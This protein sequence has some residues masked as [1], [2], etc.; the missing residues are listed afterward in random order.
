MKINY[1]ALQKWSDNILISIF[2]LDQKNVL[3]NIN[4]NINIISKS[5]IDEFYNIFIDLYIQTIEQQQLFQDIIDNITLQN[6]TKAE[7]LKLIKNTD[8]LRRCFNKL[9]ILLP[10]TDIIPTLSTS[11]LWNMDAIHYACIIMNNELLNNAIAQ[12]LSAEQVLTANNNKL[13]I[14]KACVHG[15]KNYYS[16]KQLDITKF[17]KFRIIRNEYPLYL[18]P[19]LSNNNFILFGKQLFALKQDELRKACFDCD[20]D[21]IHDLQAVINAQKYSSIDNINIE[22]GESISL[23][24]DLFHSLT[25]TDQYI[26]IIYINGNVITGEAINDTENGRIHHAALFKKYC[27]NE[28]LH[29]FDKI[30]MPITDWS[31]MVKDLTTYSEEIYNLMEKYKCVRAVQSIHGTA[32]VIIIATDNMKEAAKAFTAQIATCNK[33]FACNSSLTELSREAKIRR[34]MQKI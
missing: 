14:T 2:L 33:V 22:V 19:K 4:A 32:V 10:T 16:E 23:N 30:Q 28:S 7:I 9:F 20:A 13:F 17:N 24:G 12:N 8:L 29:K 5:S 18:I 31:N 6:V 26:P 21:D 11:A 1:K 25:H 34:L 27:M 3:R 15:L